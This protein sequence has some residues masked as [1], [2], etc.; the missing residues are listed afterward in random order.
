MSNI[1]RFGSDPNIIPYAVSSDSLMEWTPEQIAKFGEATFDEV[2]QLTIIREKIF[3]D[4]TF[5]AASSDV[6]VMRAMD[7]LESQIFAP[8]H[9]ARADG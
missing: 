7:R 6:I 3:Q 4:S 2:V 5:L 1:I 8:G 9:G